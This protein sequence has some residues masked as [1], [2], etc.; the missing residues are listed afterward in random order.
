MHSILEVEAK[1]MVG[2]YFDPGYVD[3]LGHASN[4]REGARLRF[5][6]SSPPRTL[7]VDS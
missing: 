2:N 5:A 4:V 6:S 7:P 1:L 3:D